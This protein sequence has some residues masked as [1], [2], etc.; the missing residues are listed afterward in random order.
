MLV[1]SNVMRKNIKR[2]IVDSPADF[3]E[4][5]PELLR[6]D[7]REAIRCRGLV[8]D[9]EEYPKY[10]LQVSTAIMRCSIIFVIENDV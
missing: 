10:G 7:L 2:I 1:L 3:D 9:L 8:S 6:D 5:D 4:A